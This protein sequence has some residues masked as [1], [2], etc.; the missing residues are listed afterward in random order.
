MPIAREQFYEQTHNTLVHG[1][2]SN[3][4]GQPVLLPILTF[5]LWGFV[6]VSYNRD[7][8]ADARCTQQRVPERPPQSTRALG[9]RKNTATHDK[10]V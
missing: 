9:N 6:H 10:D 4:N 7:E 2:M 8:K 1:L 3:T 5:G